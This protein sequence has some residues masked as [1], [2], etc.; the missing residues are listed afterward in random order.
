MKERRMCSGRLVLL[1]VLSLQHS[2]SS[3]YCFCCHCNIW[4][5]GFVI[6]TALQHL[7]SRFYCFYRHYSIWI[8][9]FIVST[10]TTTFGFKSLMFLLSLQHLDSRLFCFYCHYNI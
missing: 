1:F 7:D 9:G 5:Q 4:I 10:F 2:D 6:S 3:S 8:Q